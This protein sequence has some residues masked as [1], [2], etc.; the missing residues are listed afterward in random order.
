MSVVRWGGMKKWNV[1]KIWARRQDALTTLAFVSVFIVCAALFAEPPDDAPA[2]QAAVRDIV[3][4]GSSPSSVGA[5]LRELYPEVAQVVGSAP[6]DG[7]LEIVLQQ[8]SPLYPASIVADFSHDALY[9]AESL[10]I[11]FPELRNETIR[12]VAM[13]PGMPGR[14]GG[15]PE[16]LLALNFRRSDLMT[17]RH[18]GGFAE[19]DLLNLSRSVDYLKSTSAL[20]VEAFCR[21]AVARPAAAF[22]RREAR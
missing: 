16:Q 7:A 9:V 22:C 19:A 4:A 11:L 2:R 21:D 3:P 10:Q 18:D 1:S 15:A 6:P 13:A 12:F 8:T 17:I 14:F 5:T 20:A